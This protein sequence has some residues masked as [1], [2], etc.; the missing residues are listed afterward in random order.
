MPQHVGP[1]ACSPPPVATYS[2]RIRHQVAA[3]R[4]DIVAEPPAARARARAL[5]I[6]HA[7]ANAAGRSG[8]SSR[9]R[10]GNLRR[11]ARGGGRPHAR[12]RRAARPVFSAAANKRELRS[13]VSSY[14]ARACAP[15]RGL[16]RL[17]PRPTRLHPQGG[18][19]W[20]RGAPTP[21]GF[22]APCR[23]RA[24]PAPRRTGG[25]PAHRAP[26]AALPRG[27]PE[28]ARPPAGP[29]GHRPRVSSPACPALPACITRTRILRRAPCAPCT[30]P[31]R[32]PAC[33]G[34]SAMRGAAGHA[35]MAR[36]PGSPRSL[37]ASAMRAPPL[38][39]AD[40]AGADRGP[41]S[42]RRPL[43]AIAVRCP[44]LFLLSPCAAPPARRGPAG[45][46]APARHAPPAPRSGGA[47]SR[48]RRRSLGG[49]RRAAGPRRTGRARTAPPRPAARADRARAPIPMLL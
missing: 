28:Y 5:C 16:G 49:P 34:T 14:R 48:P 3:Q 23:G 19:P 21:A 47:G 11:K 9:G 25:A 45:L 35:P 27:G 10:S 8:R 40:P 36:G 20:S 13:A 31:W 2:I 15:P 24:G 42:P 17:A 12:G 33:G 29:A 39:R 1:L 32:A 37:A 7:A 41:A 4:A 46:H 30:M 22:P 38:P 44:S 43:P 18:M 26:L 6:A